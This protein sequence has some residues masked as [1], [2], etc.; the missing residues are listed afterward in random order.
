MWTFPNFGLVIKYFL[1]LLENV[2]DYYNELDKWYVGSRLSDLMLLSASNCPIF[3]FAYASYP[4]GFL[5]CCF[6]YYS[7]IMLSDI[8]E[9][10][11][12]KLTDTDY[13]RFEVDEQTPFGRE[14]AEK[15]LRETPEIKQKAMEDLRKLLQG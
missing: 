5:I 1:F 10:P 11:A 6:A 12:I 3:F 2:P 8:G 4:N 13:L 9:L 15:E 14:I 7:F